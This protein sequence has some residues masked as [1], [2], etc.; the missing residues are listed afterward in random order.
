MALQACLL[1]L[2]WPRIGRHAQ[3]QLAAVQEGMVHQQVLWKGMER[4][5]NG[6]WGLRYDRVP[7]RSQGQASSANR[8]ATTKPNILQPQAAYLL[9]GVIRVLLDEVQEGAAA[10]GGAAQAHRM[11]VFP[12]ILCGWVGGGQW[13]EK[14]P[15]E[16]GYLAGWLAGQAVMQWRRQR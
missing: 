15:G 1:L 16:K 14:G 6:G 10:G 13:V 3:Q 4:A 9:Q 11:L 8:A 5:Q 7:G 12:L 2:C